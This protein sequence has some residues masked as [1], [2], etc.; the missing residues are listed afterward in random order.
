MLDSGRRSLD[1]PVP[2]IPS[3]PNLP[4]FSASQGCLDKMTGDGQF[5]HRGIDAR[6]LV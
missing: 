5:F 3:G 1:I 4:L 2:S 6:D